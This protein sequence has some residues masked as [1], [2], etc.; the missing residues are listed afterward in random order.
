EAKYALGEA[1]SEVKGLRIHLGQRLSGWVAANRQTIVNSDPTLD[2]GE[3]ARCVL[4][5]LR[6]CL[7]TPLL[8]DDTLVG[9]LTLYS[10]T[11]DGFNEDH[12]RMVEIVA[13]EIGHTFK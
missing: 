3:V 9:V 5:R 12:R 6:S 11:V 4:P 7:S 1:T 10:V 8:S 2:L 13:R